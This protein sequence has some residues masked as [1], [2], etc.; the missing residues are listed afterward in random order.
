[1]SD[2][3]IS[4]LATA[5]DASPDD[6][7]LRLKLASLLL[8]T[9]RTGEALAHIGAA[10][11]RDPASGSPSALLI[12]HPDFP[13][14]VEMAGRK[15]VRGAANTAARKILGLPSDEPIKTGPKGKQKYTEH[16]RSIESVA[17]LLTNH[18]RAGEHRATRL[19]VTL[20][21]SDVAGGTVI[22]PE[23]HGL[24]GPL[25]AMVEGRPPTPP[26]PS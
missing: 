21:G 5:V 6:V 24:Y 13:K 3:V 11:V 9:G 26:M 25:V 22:V 12:A 2:S 7:P 1:M 10:I 15:H 19:T 4:R 14:Y 8:E 23:D 17:R 20:S 18:A 16:G